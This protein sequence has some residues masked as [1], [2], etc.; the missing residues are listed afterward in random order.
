[1]ARC[2]YV[3]WCVCVRNEQQRIHPENQEHVRVVREQLQTEQVE[4]QMMFAL[5]L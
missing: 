3:V 2:K 1:M 4:C 5:I